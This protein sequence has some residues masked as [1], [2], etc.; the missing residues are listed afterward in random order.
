MKII[1]C[2]LF[3]FLY[4]FLSITTF[5]TTKTASV[6]GYWNNTTTWGGSSIPTA[7]DDIVINTGV[8][9]MLV[10]DYTTSAS[11]TLNGTG[12]F[13]MNGYNLTIGSL[14]AT[15]SSNISNGGTSKILNVGSDGTSTSYSGLIS[16]SI[17]FTKTGTGTLTFLAGHNFNGNTTINAGTLV[18]TDN[19][20][21]YSSPTIT[22]G[23]SGTLELNSTNTTLDHW[24]LYNILAGTGVINKTGVGWIQSAVNNTFSGTFN[25]TA[26]VF[27]S[28]FTSGD[29]SNFSADVN[30]SS[31]ALLDLRGWNVTVGS[32]SGAGKVGS[33]WWSLATLTIGAGN[34]TGYT[35]T[36]TIEGNATTGSQGV[37][38]NPN[39]SVLSVSKIG[40]GTQIVTGA[41]IYTGGT[42]ITN[43][44]FQVGNAISNGSIGSGTYSI[45]SGS[46]LYLNY[47]TA[48]EPTW[49]NIS[50]AGTL[51]LNSAQAANGSAFWTWTHLSLPLSFTGTLQ[52][53]NGR[54]QG[55]PSNLGGTTNIVMNNN[56]QFLAYDGSVNGNSYTYP[57]TFSLSGMGF[58]E[59]GYQE[60]VLRVSGMNATFSGAITLVGN[61]GF[62]TQDVTNSTM[63]VS[64]AISGAYAVTCTARNNF[65]TFTGANTYTGV[66]TINY[67][68]FKAGNNSALGTSVAG[69]SISSG[70]TFD[71]NGYSFG[72]EEFTLTGG[73]IVNN[74]AASWNTMQKLTVTANS[75]I[76]GT[77][78]WSISY[79]GMAGSFT[80]NSGVT[81]TKTGNNFIQLLWLPLIN[82][83]SFLI[84]AGSFGIQGYDAWGAGNITLASG[85][86]L[87]I[88]SWGNSTV[89]YPP[90][91]SNGGSINC[92]QSD[93]SN[94]VVLAGNV[95]L[96]NATTITTNSCDFSISGII[97]GTGSLTKNGAG[98]LTLS[99]ADTYTGAT[100]INIG[101]VVLNTV[102]SYASSITTVNSSGILELKSTDQNVDNWRLNTILAGSGTINKTGIGWIQ[103]YT[104]IHTFSG[105]FNIQA[106]TF[107]TS[108]LNSD[109]SGITADFTISAGALLDTRGQAIT[110]GSINGAGKIG[111]SWSTT[112]TV[113]T[114]AGNKSGSFSGN[115]SGN[116]SS[117]LNDISNPNGGVLSLIKTGT[118]TQTLSGTNTF[119]NGVSLNAGKLT[120]NSSTALGSGT[121]TIAN[122]TSIDNTSGG[123]ITLSTNNTQTWNGDFT[124]VGTN[125]LNVGT[126]AVAMGATLRT[127][128]TTASTLTVGGI[129]SGTGGLTKTGAGTLTL[130]GANTYTGT[131]TIN[132]GTLILQNTYSSPAYSIASGAVL[133]LNRTVYTDYT[134][135]TTFS[136]AGTLRKT[137][138]GQVLWGL[139]AA[140]F[141][142]SAGSLIDVQAGNMSGSSSGNEVWTN[143]YSGLTVASGATF[144]GV[145]GSVKV[146]ALNGAGTVT[147]GWLG[148]G[149]IT[150]GI[151]NGSGTFSGV[152]GDFDLASGHTGSIIKVGTGTQTL[153][154]ANIF[155]RGV[156]LN[157]G[158]L[159]INS[160]TALGSGTFTIAN[161]TSIDNT[162]GGSITLST[163]NVQT[164]NGDFTFIGTNPLNI[165]TGAVA[166]GSTL[167]TVTTAASTLTVGGTISG[168]GGLTKAGAGTMTLGG[169]SFSNWTGPTTISTGILNLG[170]Q[171]GGDY[172]ASTAW[173]INTGA[174]LFQTSANVISNSA[175]VTVNN[176]G[177]WDLNGK[178]ECVGYIA[179]SGSISNTAGLLQL[180]LPAIGTGSEFSGVIS[181]SAQLRIRGNITAGKQIL[182]GLN[183]YTA[184]TVIQNGTLSINTIQNVS[185][186]ASAVG[187]PTTVANGTIQL[188]AATTTGILEY[189]GTAITTDRVIDLSGTTGGGTITQSG[190]GLLKFTSAFTATGIGVKTVTLQ[191][192]SAGTGEINGAIIDGSGTTIVTKLGTGT[193]TLSGVNTYTGLTTINGG[194]VKLG[195]STALGSI[196][197]GTVV[198][199]GY[200]LDLNGQTYTNAEALTIIG[201]GYLNSGVIFNSNTT[202]A[203]F[204]GSITLA[205]SSTVTADHQITLSG[206]ISNNQHFTKTGTST[207]VFSN[208]T[209]TVNNLA[210]SDG[211]LDGASSTVNVYG[212]FTSSGTFIPNTNGIVL[213]GSSIQ[214]IPAVSFNNLTINNS[215]GAN[216]AGNISVA[217]ILT[218][219]NGILTTGAYSI[220]LGTSGSIVE[221]T[222]SV[223]AP[224]SYVIGTVKATRTLMQNT[225][226]TF[227]GIG[228]EL[229]EA[230][231]NNNATLVVRT[232]GTGCNGNG[233]TGITRYFT[234][235]PTTDIGLNGTMVFY[236]FD[237]EITGNS[238]ANLKIFKSTDSRVHWTMQNNANDNVNNKLTL[239][240]ISSFS[241]WTASD[242]INNSLPIEL[243]SFNVKKY[244]EKVDLL[245]ITASETNND[246][247][248]LER[249]SDGNDWFSIY[250]CNGVGTS[251]KEHHYSYNDYNPSTGINYYRLKQT[252]FDGNFTY[253]NIKTVR[254]TNDSISMQIYPIPA[255]AEQITI[256][257]SCFKTGPATIAV[258]DLLGQQI[259]NGEIELGSSP[260][261]IQL[262]DI[263]NLIPGTYY[264]TIS[265][266]DMMVRKK[267]IVE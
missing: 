155:T 139:S 20:A 23:A 197:A 258:F 107:G 226:N 11:V 244:S 123:S 245:W 89:I 202:P 145:E 90:I 38:S 72:Q 237:N 102:T 83:G 228:V 9:V 187:A 221:A 140:T 259:C 171:G 75:T 121:F 261:K 59:S 179:G 119:S 183:T 76:G 159:N 209:V 91:V 2:I 80:I 188:G 46:K 168:S 158:Q 177:I 239:S 200:A 52:V 125:A 175:V 22:V 227:G 169:I 181:G 263:C 229:T 25:I 58:G 116:A 87:D 56:S 161:G 32:L 26:G 36:G 132:A 192:S 222:P 266:N 101:T 57:Q 251:T 182:S 238:E 15:G 204:P 144:Q 61:T 191:G 42:S 234:I 186:G 28:A 194:I 256:F 217:G 86:T 77:N 164:W 104:N 166:M 48:S 193:W 73:S 213:L 223:T 6:T 207:L 70:A 255:K 106:G 248:T 201:I 100:T 160:T 240:G 267:I 105:S 39:T 41:N 170:T 18:L 134:T 214:T 253:S 172:Y 243:K 260:F 203:S 167:R 8:T 74:G 54:I 122:G 151:N 246:F 230:N 115:I 4:F 138:A 131:T 176:G 178:S 154:G 27:G 63:T 236:Y 108:Y 79:S 45:S 163:N 1:N 157:A 47:A 109:W 64:G 71:I 153:S 142:L 232:T 5:A 264:V 10:A 114:G 241:D 24:V 195:S 262:S 141:A 44:T 88:A 211:T 120:I 14:T 97:S 81:V 137:G 55:T 53:D 29:W 247:F 37:S 98:T 66:T 218:L 242:G 117:A 35:F 40:T 130:S 156:T 215:T 257:V 21:W 16:G 126:G 94:F 252:D 148:T 82:N 129:I 173:T 149:S 185:G 68:T 49:A 96:N 250:T 254:F 180:D 118:G 3:L 196:A 12:N 34:K 206:T 216:L 249:S 103:T 152:I 17:A 111:T 136:G 7:T 199:D 33:T 43:G 92:S 19:A 127:V 205:N 208:N 113:T 174:T 112:S 60:G 31:G 84:N 146:D 110:V 133:E 65:I 147:S 67:G 150:V 13:E 189:T 143:N 50:G 85:T 78:N 62:L 220:D 219:T 165:G 51:E 233:K 224:T 124:F 128:T 225:N 212:N 198:N 135:S 231:V 30:I 210:I 95:T 235:N 99:G 69:T 265:N 162:S 184:M 190:T 93:G